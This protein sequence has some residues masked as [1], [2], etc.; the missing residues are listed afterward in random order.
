MDEVRC[1]TAGD[2][3]VT[4]GRQRDEL[5]ASRDLVR[6][7]LNAVPM[8]V[9][10][11]NDA[12][13][14]VYANASVH[15]LLASSSPEPVPGLA[16]G[17]DFHCIHARP[18][19]FG[20]TETPACRICGLAQ[21]VASALD[22]QGTVSDCRLTCDLAGESASLDLRAWATPL[23]VGA[24]SLS[25]LALADI[26]DEKR[27]AVLENVC[28]H[29]LLNALTG[30]RGLL[31]VLGQAEVADCPAICT[32]LDRMTMRAIDEIG[33][34]RLL[35]QAE[36]S[37]L[38]VV[39]GEVRTGELLR[40]AVQLLGS[41]PAARGK[42]LVLDGAVR[43]MVLHSDHRLLQRIVENMVLNALE[44]T[45]PD[46]TVTVGCRD[47]DGG[48]DLWVHNASVM[49]ADVQLQ[50]FQRSFSTKGRGRGLGTYSIRLLSSL[51]GG[52]ASFESGPATGTTFHAVI[53]LVPSP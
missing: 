48:A 1:E 42:R 50:V 47:A 26:S 51:L 24:S 8:P 3:G 44:A 5:F 40:D 27:R 33:F 30:I 19:R 12:W 11:I 15:R 2:G 25:V 23:A 36:A 29:D 53:P 16:E 7:L 41:H 45:P 9:L 46:G 18:A 14:V 37:E 10:V 52:S 43:D 22:G 38:T 13:Q 21:V 49:P 6:A 20:E 39:R 34:L 35:A 32:S 31:Y 4:T 28:F 17:D